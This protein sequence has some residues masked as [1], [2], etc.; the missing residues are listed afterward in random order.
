[1][2]RGIGNNSVGGAYSLAAQQDII[3]GDPLQGPITP[4]SGTADVINPRVSGNYMVTTGSADLAT[5]AAPL[6]GTDDGLTIA[7]QSSTAFA[8]RITSTGNIRA[9][10]A[11]VNS[12]T[13]NN[14]AGAMMILRAFNGAWFLI[15]NVGALTVA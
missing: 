13:L 9:G 4:L 8:H 5:L 2:S 12:I 7:F 1:M 11:G 14:V 6:A 10:I 15:G 3:D